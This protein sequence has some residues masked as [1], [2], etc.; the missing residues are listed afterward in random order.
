VISDRRALG[1]L[2]TLDRGQWLESMRAFADLAPDLDVEVERILCWNG[3]G[4][5]QLARLFGTRDGGPFENEIA[6]VLITEGDRIQRNEIFDVADP[7]RALARFAE[8]CGEA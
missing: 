2:G 4:R 6:S 1:V 5:V 7:D 3:L 8:L